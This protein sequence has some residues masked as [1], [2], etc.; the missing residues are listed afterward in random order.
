MTTVPDTSEPRPLGLRERNRRLTA[1]HIQQATLSLLERRGWEATT[2]AEI[3]AE[4]GIS[5]RTFFRYFDSKE[6]AAFPAQRRVWLAASTFVPASDRPDAIADEVTALLRSAM[7]SADDPDE[8]ELHRRMARLFGEA[9]RLHVVA[10]TQ[11]AALV[12]ALHDRLTSALPDADPVVLRGIV[13]SAMGLWRTAWWHWGT[14]LHGND[15]ASPADS[16][17]AAVRAIQRVRSL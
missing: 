3:A 13:E 4:A 6:H 7:I 17:A 9:P 14:R 15:G 12:L 2:V 1:A 11:D 10:A 8:L 5:A 16:F